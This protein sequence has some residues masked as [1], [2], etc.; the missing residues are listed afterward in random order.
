MR[1]RILIVALLLAALVAPVFAAQVTVE[2][3]WVKN[4]PAVQYFRY[5][6]D[7]EADDAWTVVDADTTSYSVSG[8]D[9]TGSYTLYLQQSY[10][11][12]YWSESASTTSQAAVPQPAVVEE[13]VVVE[14][15]SA[16]DVA[17]PVE[18]P[19]VTETP[20]VEEV[21]AVVE[22]TP[23]V[24]EPAAPAQIPA[25]TVAA[26]RQPFTFTLSFMGGVGLNNI[27][28]PL[29]Y[30]AQA[31]LQLGFENIISNSLLGWDIKLNVGAIAN[32]RYAMSEISFSNLFS[33][34]QYDKSLYADLLTGVNLTAGI[35]QFYLDGGARLVMDYGDFRGDSLFSVG[36][37]YGS[38]QAAGV[39]GF[40]LNFNWFNVALEGQYLYDFTENTHT[41]V[42]RLMFGF[43]F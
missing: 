13:P 42:P 37:F 32:P 5:Q 19:V 21:P 8:L 38:V 22:E 18:E 1:K 36:N 12:V 4:D 27:G 31:G 25:Q 28:G 33:I 26:P 14:E 39:L 10:D 40:R 2:W 20:V 3:N 9:A 6:L 43:N 41:A 17:V 15:V 29:D 7:G 23:V 11:G 24:E 34:S 30:D 35:T 16:A